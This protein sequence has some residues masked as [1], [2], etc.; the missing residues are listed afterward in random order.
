M[1]DGQGVKALDRWLVLARENVADC[2][3]FRVE[4][5]RSIPAP[6]ADDVRSGL[7]TA[8][9]GLDGSHAPHDFFAL[10]SPDFVNVV[11]ITDDDQ[12]V[13]VEQYRHGTGEVTLEV[14]GGLV[15]DGEDAV[16]AGLRELREETGYIGDSVEILGVSR[17]NPAIQNNRLTTLLV[18]GARL[19]AAQELD[20]HEECVVHT[21]PFA[22]L[23][24]MVDDGR[25]DHAL[26]LVALFR[27]LRWRQS[28]S[29]AP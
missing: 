4:R 26:V 27:A 22:E 5:L 7:D 10:A 8:A 3:V 1:G 9:W 13:L 29:V 21:V 12:V 28:R 15:D 25:V 14:P 17:P 6:S 11:A 23:M 19:Q 18:R 16:A 2:R 20:A 24:S